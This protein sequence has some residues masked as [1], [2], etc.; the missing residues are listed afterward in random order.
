M[1][2]T[3]LAAPLALGLNGPAVTLASR[4][5]AV[6]GPGR[7]A[8]GLARLVAR[9][10]REGANLIT[11]AV[12]FPFSVH[13]YIPP[14]TDIPDLAAR[15]YRPDLYHEAAVAVGLPAAILPDALEGYVEGRRF[16]LDAAAQYAAEAPLSRLPKGLSRR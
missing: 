13:S 10:Q 4:M 2:P 7:S 16:G 5:A 6:V 8:E 11:L 15:V 3:R 12:V 14:E 1:D 9:R